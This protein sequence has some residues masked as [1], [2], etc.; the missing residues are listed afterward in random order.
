MKIRYGPAAVMHV[1][2]S[3]SNFCLFRRRKAEDT[4]IGF[5]REGGK[6]VQSRNTRSQK[7]RFRDNIRIASA[8]VNRE[9]KTD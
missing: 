7:I 5:A 1:K 3:V 6:N 4:A 8:D 9:F 2:T